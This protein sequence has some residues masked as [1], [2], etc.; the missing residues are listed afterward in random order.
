MIKLKL[1]Y[2]EKD[3]AEK[4]FICEEGGAAE[5]LTFEVVEKYAT[6]LLQLAANGEDATY[7]ID[8]SDD[9]NLYAETIKKTFDGVISDD[10]LMA[11]YREISAPQA[12]QNG[13]ENNSSEQIISPILAE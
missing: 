1:F 7:G 10:E 5:L 8:C 11:L 12:S 9:L 13:P 4:V 6:K 2:G 3:E